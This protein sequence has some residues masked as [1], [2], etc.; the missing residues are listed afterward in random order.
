MIHCGDLCVN[1]SN[2][3]EIS[4]KARIERL[5]GTIA[6]VWLTYHYLEKTRDSDVDRSEF[7]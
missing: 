6:K 7:I 1:G 3:M 4:I 5:T 2:A